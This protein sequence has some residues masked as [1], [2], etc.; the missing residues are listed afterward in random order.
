[1]ICFCDLM[2]GK[3]FVYLLIYCLQTF[4]TKKSWSTRSQD[5]GGMLGRL[6]KPRSIMH[7]IFTKRDQVFKR[8]IGLLAKGTSKHHTV[9]PWNDWLMTLDLVND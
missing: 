8:K 6:W 1:M 4:C 5:H 7:Y 9:R 2:Y 3:T